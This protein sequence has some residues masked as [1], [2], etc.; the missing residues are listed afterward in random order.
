[1]AG[2]DKKVLIIVYYWPPSGGSGVQRWMYF[3]KYLSDFGIIPIVLTVSPDKAS[4]KDWDQSNCEM[5]KDVRT[6]TTNTF[7]L[8]KLYSFATSGSTTKGIPQGHVGA[9]KHGL[10]GK[11]SSFIRGNIFIPDARIGWKFFAVKEAFK[12]IR[13][14]KIDLIITSGPPHSTH[15]IGK[16]LKKKLGVTWVAD[17]RDPWSELYYNKDLPRTGWAKKLDEKL[18]RQVL[19]RSDMVLTIGPSLQKLLSA[20]VPGQKDKFH[21][22]LNGYD[23]DA[24]MKIKAEPDGLFKITFI[25]QFALAQPYEGIIRS[26]ELFCKDHEDEAGKLKICL[27]G[28]F[29]D[30]ILKQFQ[31]LPGIL[32]E[33][34]GRIQHLDA[35][36]LMKYSQL[37]LN[38]LAEVEASK[39]LISGKLMEYISTGNPIL[40]IGDPEGDAARLL[41]TLSNSK[42]FAKDDI[43][44]I[45]QFLNFI[46][47]NWKS[48]NPLFHDGA[49]NIKNSRYETTGQLASLLK[50]I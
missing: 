34:Y 45:H 39:I 1:M 5:V 35:L 26:L 47:E 6:Y 38:S 29:D 30:F 16:K 49:E 22:I 11:I 43:A 15:L 9:N 18:E 10:F 44:G 25:G 31:K 21:Y 20:K 37:L 32:V 28:T 42:M 50:N 46:Y 8:I 24:M 7:E 36:K 14:E 17:F 33:Y 12:I 4:Y 23:R 3:A 40:C 27:A 2:K 13:K 19:E 41:K 48:G